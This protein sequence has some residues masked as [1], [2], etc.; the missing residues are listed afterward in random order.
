MALCAVFT[1]KIVEKVTIICNNIL[2]QLQACRVYDVVPMLVLAYFL[3]VH[4][5]KK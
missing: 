3:F 2:Y 5:V 1:R 4:K